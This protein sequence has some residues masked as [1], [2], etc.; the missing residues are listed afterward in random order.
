M[1][2]QLTIVTNFICTKDNDKES[3]MH[4]KSNNIE[5]LINEKANEVI[6]K[7]FEYLLHSFQIGLETSMKSSDLI[8][9]CVHLT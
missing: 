2:I 7:L 4:S 8:F 9:D 5:I 1:E 6:G 3:L